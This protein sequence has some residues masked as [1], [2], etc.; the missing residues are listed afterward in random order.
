MKSFILFCIALFALFV[1]NLSEPWV[2]PWSNMPSIKTPPPL[3]S[4]NGTNLSS[5]V[6]CFHYLHVVSRGCHWLPQCGSCK[7]H[8]I[9][10]IGLAQSIIHTV[11]WP[12]P[13]SYLSP[14]FSEPSL[15]VPGSSQLIEAKSAWHF[16]FVHRQWNV[17]SQMFAQSY[18]SHVMIYTMHQ[19]L[20]LDTDNLL[21]LIKN[22]IRALL[23]SFD[24][25]IQQSRST[26]SAPCFYFADVVMKDLFY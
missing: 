11:L 8:I 2:S 1:L 22:I 4:F 25:V 20:H 24:I 26:F 21:L 15:G 14:T 12:L 5:P 6:E 3:L 10:D 7:D 16:P 23:K 19:I 9:S 18:R 17:R 13:T